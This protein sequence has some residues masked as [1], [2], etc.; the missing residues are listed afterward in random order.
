MRADF[1]TKPL[2]GMLFY[3]LRDLIMNIAPITHRTGVCC[4]TRAKDTINPM[5]TQRGQQKKH[6]PHRGHASEY[7]RQVHRSVVPMILSRMGIRTHRIN[8]V[9]L[10][11]IK[12]RQI[13]QQRERVNFIRRHATFLNAMT[14]RNSKKPNNLGNGRTKGIIERL[15]W[16]LGQP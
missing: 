13:I 4:R 16:L 10:T 3:R 5:T 11:R 15:F 2:Q 9:S 7:T 6:K 14:W 8:I 1:F 12:L